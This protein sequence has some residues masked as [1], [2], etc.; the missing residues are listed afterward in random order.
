M[1]TENQ[2]IIWYFS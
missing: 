1:C 2:T